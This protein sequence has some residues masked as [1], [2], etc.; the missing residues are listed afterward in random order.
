MG[1]GPFL[2]FSCFQ[3]QPFLS[4]HLFLVFLL[5]LSLHLQ[6]PSKKTP[7]ASNFNFARSWYN[8]NWFWWISW[9]SYHVVSI[10][11]LE[12]KIYFLI[13]KGPTFKGNLILEAF[14]KLKKCSFSII[15]FFLI[16]S[17]ANILGFKNEGMMYGSWK[18]T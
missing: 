13:I 4:L 8:H 7:F 17:K 1:L 3:L 15:R 16:N 6:Q 10:Q 18:K 11:I 9:N 12:E 2:S 14:L 5:L